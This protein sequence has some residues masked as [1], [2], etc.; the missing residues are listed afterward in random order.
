MRLVDLCPDGLPL[1]TPDAFVTIPGMAWEYLRVYSYWWAYDNNDKY[2]CS[3]PIG[4]ALSD[5]WLPHPSCPLRGKEAH[6]EWWDGDTWVG[7]GS[8]PRVCNYRHGQRVTHRLGHWTGTVDDTYIE[9]AVVPDGET[10]EDAEYVGE[11]EL[12][13]VDEE[14]GCASG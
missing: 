14:S 13:S 1:W 2:V 12:L 7:R 4:R 9:Y 5:N 6:P 11:G 8:E 10:P 3:L